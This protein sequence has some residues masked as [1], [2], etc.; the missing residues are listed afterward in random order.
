MK[1]VVQQQKK[2]FEELDMD[3]LDD[4]RDEMDEMRYQ[5]EYMN[6]LMNRDYQVDVDEADLD[7]ELL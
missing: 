2:I 6:E 4:I 5:T 7:D 3:E 1:G